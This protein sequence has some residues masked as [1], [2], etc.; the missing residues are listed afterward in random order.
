MNHKQK[1]LKAKEVRSW[2][3][4]NPGATNEQIKTAVGC[5]P[6]IVQNL[7]LAYWKRENGIVKWYAKEG[8]SRPWNDK[9][10]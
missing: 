6:T 7:G 10:D 3:I 1:I 9:K 4:K 5:G 8:V 2:L